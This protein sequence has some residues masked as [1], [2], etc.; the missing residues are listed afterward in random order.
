MGLRVIEWAADLGTILVMRPPDLAAFFGLGDNESI[1]IEWMSCEALVLNGTQAAAF[2]MIN[3]MDME[4]TVT[5]PITDF[6]EIAGVVTEAAVGGARIGGQLSGAQRNAVF[7]N[8]SLDTGPPAIQKLKET[9]P[10]GEWIKRSL[11]FA[12]NDK[13][14]SFVFEMKFFRVPRGMFWQPE[15]DFGDLGQVRTTVTP[16]AEFHQPQRGGGADYHKVSTVPGGS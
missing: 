16:G 1:V 10:I 7:W 3:E 8:L 2:L 12:K 9:K 4:K 6:E 15:S 11:V 13:D 14:D 5:A